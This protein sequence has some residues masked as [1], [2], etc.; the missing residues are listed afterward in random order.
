MQITL[1]GAL[2]EAET[3][4]P[5]T[6]IVPK[7]GGNRFEGIRSSARIG[8]MG[9][10]QQRRRRARGAGR[11]DDWADQ[12]VGRQ[13]CDG[14]SHQARQDL[15]LRQLPRRRKPHEHSRRLS[16]TCIPAIASHWDYAPDPGVA[17]ALASAKTIDLGA[18]SPRRSRLATRSA[19]TTTISGTA[20]SR[21][22]SLTEG[23]RPRGEDWTTGV[24]FGA[25]FLT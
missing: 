7:T 16:T 22:Q 8:Q 21:Q 20:T 18:R 23:C 6:N 2:G 17:V 3:G 10:G 14:R 12:A 1:S 24:V 9:A 4:G 5:V 25:A 19:S 13:L 15:V 11:H